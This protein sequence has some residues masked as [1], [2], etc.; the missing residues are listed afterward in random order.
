[1]PALFPEGDM[2]LTGGIPAKP[3]DIADAIVMLASDQA[4][5][6]TGTLLFVDGGQ[7]LLR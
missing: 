7:S 3:E 4:R 1:M 6:V 2:P 5:H